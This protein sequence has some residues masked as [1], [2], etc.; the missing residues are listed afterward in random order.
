MCVK[1]VSMYW[2]KFIHTD[3]CV[4]C[5]QN[6]IIWCII[7][8]MLCTVWYMSPIVWSE[9]KM[10][11]RIVINTTIKQNEIDLL[12][13]TAKWDTLYVVYDSYAQPLGSTLQDTN[14]LTIVTICVSFL[15]TQ[16]ATMSFSKAWQHYGYI[17]HMQN[18]KLTHSSVNPIYK[19][20]SEKTNESLVFSSRY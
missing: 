12:S 5:F 4:R 14:S 9:E 13:F 18:M 1:R 10:S 17:I 8:F 16:M 11:Y 20:I 3:T 2:Y 19:S 7:I 6:Y 15:M